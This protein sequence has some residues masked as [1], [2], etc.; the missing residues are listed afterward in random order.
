VWSEDDIQWLK[1]HI[2]KALDRA[3]GEDAVVY[4]KIM[5]IPNEDLVLCNECVQKRDGPS[6]W[7]RSI[8]IGFLKKGKIHTNPDSYRIIALE[9]CILKA[10]TLPIHK[11]ITE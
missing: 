7:F 4:A 6:I 11:R 5:D 9:S 3:S 8:I 1:N 2:R 10:L